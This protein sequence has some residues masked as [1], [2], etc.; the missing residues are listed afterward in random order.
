[1]GAEREQHGTLLGHSGTGRQSPVLGSVRD[2]RIKLFMKIVLRTFI[3]VCFVYVVA[4]LVELHVR[5]T[6]VPRATAKSGPVYNVEVSGGRFHRDV[7][8]PEPSLNSTEMTLAAGRKLLAE[9]PSDTDGRAGNFLLSLCDAGQFRAA[10]EFANESPTNLRAGWLRAVF[11]R[12]A[13]KHPQDAVNALSSIADESQ[14]IQLFQT[15]TSTWAANNPATLAD[16]A[17][18]LPSGDDKTYALNLVADNWSMQDPEAF[19]TWLRTAP[20]GVNMDEAIAKMISSTDEAN[21]SSEIAMEWVEA[22]NDPALRYN[23]LMWVL[24]QWNQSNPAAAEN[25]LSRISW[26]DDFQRQEILSTLETPHAMAS[27]NI[28]GD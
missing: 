2:L 18:S 25:Y 24:G 22:I 12:W 9:D 19:S 23:S 11:T 5:E 6:V 26:L 4:R 28:G 14:R 21:R 7:P 8:P 27:V 1:M 20:P 13:G 16:Y 15:I 17:E 10:L 3:V